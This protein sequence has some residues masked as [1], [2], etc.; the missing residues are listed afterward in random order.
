MAQEYGRY[1][2]LKVGIF[3]GGCETGTNHSAVELHGFLNYL[4]KVALTGKTYTIFGYKGKQVRDQ[5]HSYD[6]V[7]LLYEFYKNPR[8]GEVYNLGGGRENSASIL[9]CITIIENIAGKKIYYNYTD[10]NRKG[11]YIC[12]ISNLNKIKKHFPEWKI[13]YSLTDIIEEMIDNIPKFL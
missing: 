8:C 3:R 5:I 1:L 9:K 11:D 2:G 4:V 12:Y 10:N 7:T 13:K 6:V